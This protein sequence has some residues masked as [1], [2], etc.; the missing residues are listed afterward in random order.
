MSENITIAIIA[1]L[2][3]GGLGAV[4]TSLI[5]R[6]KV[7]AEV[8]KTGAEAVKTEAEVT[9]VIT[10]AARE[11]LSEYRARND[12]TEVELAEIKRELREVKVEMREREKRYRQEQ[13][14]QDTQIENTNAMVMKLQLANEILVRQIRALGIEPLVPPADIGT[15]PVQDL[16]DIADSLADIE[17][18]RNIRKKAKSDGGANDENST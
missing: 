2:G 14:L 5:N 16:R 1:L 6:R 15:M 3:S 4:V 10:A 17:Y 11:L 18:R 13:A 8:K 7:R 9:K 12:E